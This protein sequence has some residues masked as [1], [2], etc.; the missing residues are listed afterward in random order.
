MEGRCVLTCKYSRSGL[1]WDGN[2]STGRNKGE[3][4]VQFGRICAVLKSLNVN[5]GTECGSSECW[6]SRDVANA[7]NF[8]EKAAG[9]APLVTGGPWGISESRAAG[10]PVRDVEYRDRD[11]PQA[12][13][14]NEEERML[15]RYTDYP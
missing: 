14:F 8:I 5:W 12:I 10:A 13:L 1:G 3:G 9:M 11:C 7:H 4:W 2:D 15:L 6:R